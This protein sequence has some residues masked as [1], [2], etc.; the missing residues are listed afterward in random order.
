[1]K[2]RRGFVTNSSS[3]SFIIARKGNVDK[4]RLGY[5]LLNQT[6]LNDIVNDFMKDTDSIE[7]FELSQKVKNLIKNKDFDGVKKQLVKEFVDELVQRS[8]D[9]KLDDWDISIGEASNET[10][11]LLDFFIY[12]LCSIDLEDFKIKTSFY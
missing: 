9:M 3:S 10:D 8:S 5:E 1:M 11:N 12:E 4:M 7:Y 2:I 6:A